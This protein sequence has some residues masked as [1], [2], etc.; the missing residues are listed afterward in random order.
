MRT[1]ADDS[2]AK[3]A[4]FY[5]S[6]VKAICITSPEN[7]ERIPSSTLYRVL[8]TFTGLQTIAIWESWLE[9]NDTIFKTEE[10]KSVIGKDLRPKK[11]STIVERFFAIQDIPNRYP[12]F[13]M[14]FFSQ[15]THL[16]ILDPTDTWRSWK[17]LELLPCLTHLSFEDDFIDIFDPR[18]GINML[19]Y[20]MLKECR[21]LQVILFILY[22]QRYNMR[23]RRELEA[24]MACRDPRCVVLP[25]P[26]HYL[27]NWDA[28]FLGK[29]DLWSI[30]EDT[31]REQLRAYQ[32]ETQQA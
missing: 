27:A 15:L 30:A 29:P 12:D 11:L 23:T 28:P 31:A 13:S 22:D 4:E 5:A 19:I 32:I 18:K 7:V 24:I 1:L 17:G 14:P 26:V 9:Q 21:T 2:I 10:Q 6:H 16:E 25:P 8:T 3:S 20:T